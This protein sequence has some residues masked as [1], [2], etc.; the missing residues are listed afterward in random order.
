LVRFFGGRKTDDSEGREEQPG[1]KAGFR[2]RYAYQKAKPEKPGKPRLV[3]PEKPKPVI[4]KKYQ[5]WLSGKELERDAA[6]YAEQGYFVQSVTALGQQITGIKTKTKGPSI[7]LAAG[8]RFT[9]EDSK[10]KVSST[11]K[12]VLVTYALTD[13]KKAEYA[14]AVE[15]S[16]AEYAA[17][18]ERYPARL[19]EYEAALAEWKANKPS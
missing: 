10:G 18:V 15:A 1:H 13:E 3:E 9:N 12:G 6:K 14:A 4:V 19:A 17:A 2:E 8:V 11:D 5:G 7:G 16:K